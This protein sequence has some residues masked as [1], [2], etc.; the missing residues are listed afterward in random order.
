MKN[1]K[2]FIFTAL[3]AAAYLL[4]S[5]S[6]M[7]DIVID[8]VYNDWTGNPVYADSSTDA[9]A[10][11][12]NFGKV[13]I[14]NNQDKIFFR[15]EIGV[16]RI[17]QTDS[18]LSLFIDSDNSSSTGYSI[19]QIGAEITFNFAT[20]SGY[21]NYSGTN[22]QITHKDITLLSSPNYSA[23]EFEISISRTCKFPNGNSVFTSP[24]IRITLKSNEGSNDIAP[25]SGS[26]ISYTLDN[27]TQPAYTKIAF[28]KWNSS[29]IRMLTWNALGSGLI[30][31][32]DYFSRI[33]KAVDPQIICFQE[34]YTADA[35]TAAALM[36]TILPGNSGD[37]WYGAKTLPDAITLSR[38]PIIKSADVDGNNA[39]LIDL[40]SYMSAD[41]LLVI[42]MHL[43]CCSYD[44][45][46]QNEVDHIMSFVRDSQAQTGDIPISFKTPI[47]ITGDTNF[48][49]YAQQMNTFLTGDIVDET[50]Y[51]GD[52][53]PDWDNTDLARLYAQHSAT[54]E[55]FTWTSS[56]SNYWP[57][58]IDYCIYTDSVLFMKNRFIVRTEEMSAEDLAYY[59]LLAGD[60]YSAAD[61]LPVIY[62]FTTETSA[63]SG[64]KLF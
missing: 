37:T 31:R 26:F 5:V 3:C 13:W 38:F 21:F 18:N 12:I 28:H 22:T 46:R 41:H 11:E 51:G 24:I 52:F 29:H 15:F 6:A 60:S 62:D 2:C 27:S 20:R 63:K 58:R 54:P 19:N 7:A 43:P 8:G 50:T 32:T 44:A 14:A 40:P 30:L 10:N 53:I 64:L 4:L 55:T 33:L 34:V 25:D 16:E 17:M 39:S 56:S 42:N 36:N 9:A 23:K 45:E 1:L 59:N 57:S 48:V 49:G 47:I 35:A 61:H